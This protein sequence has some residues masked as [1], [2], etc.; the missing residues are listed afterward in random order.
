MGNINLNP[1]NQGN[2]NNKKEEEKKPFK[3]PEA[4]LV[5]IGSKKRRNLS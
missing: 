2:Q 3:R 4:G 1:G 5:K